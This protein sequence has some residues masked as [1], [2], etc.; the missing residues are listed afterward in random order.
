MTKLDCNTSFSCTLHLGLP[1]LFAGIL[2]LSIFPANAG[3]QNKVTI[4]KA[5]S[6]V[7]DTYK[8]ERVRKLMG[9]VHLRSENM[10]MLCDSAYQFVNKSEMRAFGNIQ[11]DTEDEKIWADSLTYFTDIDFSQLRGR[12]VI[13]NDSTTLFGN[14]VDYRFTTKVA[15][16]L[17]DI[18][19]EDQQ[20]ILLADSGFYY[21]EA[22]SAVF[23]GHVQ[24]RDSLKYLEGDS[25]FTNR[26]SEYYEL[27]GNVF[28][29]DQENKTMIRGQYLES[30]STG[31]S[32]L[33]E[34]AWLKNFESDTTDSTSTD[35]THIQARKILS[36]EQRS[37]QDTT[38]IVH[39]Y[40]NVRIW[41]PDFSALSDTT[42]YT[43]STDTFELWS[44]ARAW[45]KQVQLTGPYIKAKI[46][47]GNI[48]SLK[49][50]P[51]PFSVQQDTSIDRLNQITGDTL[52]ADFNEG[53]L[54]QIYVFGNS[55]LLRFTKNEA[56]DTDGAL[57]MTAP[58]IRIFF[59]RGELIEMKGI[60]AINGSY[61]PESE[62][63]ANKKLEGF[64][65]DPKMR[66]NRPSPPMQRRFA[67]VPDTVFFK[68]PPRYIEHLEKSKP[69]SPKLI[70]NTP[71]KEP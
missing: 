36:L 61:L 38:T 43:D 37:A 48:D 60:G 21:R 47:D 27:Y 14:S 24:L 55:H 64:S 22:D 57:D 15:H 19:F 40:E 68:L 13:E 59:E 9:N 52:H 5:D 58:D 44:N 51:Q 66:P 12:V 1:F 33:K 18:R 42:Q 32:L 30:D 35:T 39:G 56:G 45:H 20:G 17:D 71:Q 16:F 31:R 69:Q 67:P 65:W 23:R 70:S 8:N 50:Y 3:A 6:I 63:T 10:E 4:L 11:I 7:G 62:Q 2:L 49:S 28:G 54:R 41:S 29:D 25:L 34:E 46:V 53:D 26:S